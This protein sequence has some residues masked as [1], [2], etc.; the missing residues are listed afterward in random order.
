MVPGSFCRFAFDQKDS[1]R[2]KC[3]RGRLLR[4]RAEY[5][6]IFVCGEPQTRRGGGGRFKSNASV[7]RRWPTR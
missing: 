6:Y 4:A 7:V 3:C 5:I 2:D 1:A